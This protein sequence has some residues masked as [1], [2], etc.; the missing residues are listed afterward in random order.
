MRRRPARRRATISWRARSTPRRRQQ[1]W[2]SRAR[3]R[4]PSWPRRAKQQVGEY[5]DRGKEYYDRGR[6]QWAEYVEKGKGLVQEQQDK[7]A[8]AIDAGKDAYANAT[9]AIWASRSWLARQGP[10]RPSDGGQARRFLHAE[11][12]ERLHDSGAI[13]YVGNVAAGCGLD[14]VGQLEVADDLCRSWLRSG[15]DRAGDRSG[16]RW[17][18]AR[19]RHASACWRS[20][21]RFARRRCR[22]STARRSSF[23]SYAP[24]LMILA[25]NLVE[26]SNV[27]RRQGGGV[28]CDS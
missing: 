9:Q 23:K 28:R 12:K 19:P 26:T 10:D 15:D 7:V 25:E 13:C 22:R 3:T 11:L 21:K 18:S 14:F 27:V 6:T 1:L 16:R 5:V 20:P 8:S 2:P 4:P 17:R 24:K